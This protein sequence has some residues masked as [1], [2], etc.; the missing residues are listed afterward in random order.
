MAPRPATVDADEDRLAQ[1]LTNLLDNAL[2][3]TPPGGRVALRT[4][5]AGNDLVLEVRDT[6]SGILPEEQPYVFE[7]FWRG[8]R[9]RSRESGGSG[10]GLAIVRQLVMLHGGTVEVESQPGQ[11]STF[12]V[13]IPRK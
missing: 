2:R 5:G 13:I 11:G 1:I 3:H 12:R 7:R 8:D 4:Y 6:G 9:S 10:L